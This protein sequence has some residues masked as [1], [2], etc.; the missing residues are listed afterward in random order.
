MTSED[1]NT[2]EPAAPAEI[3]ANPFTGTDVEAILRERD[4][5]SNEQTATPEQ[6]AWCERAAA[7]LGPRCADRSSM[8]DLLGLVFRYDAADLMTQMDTHVTMSRRDARDVLRQLG[9]LVL[10]PQPFTSER[11]KEIVTS[12]KEG[13]DIQ[14]RELFHPLR[15][16]LAGR[17]GEGNLDRVILLVDEAAAAGFA[18]NVKTVRQRALEFCATLD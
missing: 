8:A 11:F 14:G 4:W 6:N 5:M 18:T 9:R 7:L 1:N 2:I 16:A 15:L 10:E 17:V 12:L 3:A 13:L